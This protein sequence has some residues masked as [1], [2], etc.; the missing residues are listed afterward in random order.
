MFHNNLKIRSWILEWVPFALSKKKKYNH[1]VSCKKHQS[2][3]MLCM[4]PYKHN[5]R[6]RH[7]QRLQCTWD[8]ATQEYC[9]VWVL[10]IYLDVLF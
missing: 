6:G 10:G 5:S 1:F 7:L 4:G 9:F 3:Y 8:C 2:H